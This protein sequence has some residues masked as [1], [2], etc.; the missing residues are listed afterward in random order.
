MRAQSWARA[1]VAAACAVAFFW[2]PDLDIR[3]LG[4]GNHRYFLF[5]SAIVPF[6]AWVVTHRRGWLLRAL[7]AGIALGV[8][9]H[10]ATDVFQRKAVVFP[11]AHTLVEGTSVDDRLWEAGNALVCGVLGAAL[12]RRSRGPTTTMGPPR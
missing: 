12:L 4:I 5:H 6:A 9:V 7:S 3:L 10:L 11:W 8:G 1:A 2:F